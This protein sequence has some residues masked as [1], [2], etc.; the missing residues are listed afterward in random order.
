ML[1]GDRSGWLGARISVPAAELA[2]R[3]GGPG[4]AVARVRVL[5]K[6]G[7]AFEARDEG[8]ERLDLGGR[9]D[10]AGRLIGSAVAR[11]NE[12]HRDAGGMGG[13]GGELE[14]AIGG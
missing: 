14:Q 3:P 5:L 6:R 11:M 2:D 10:E 1:E 4:K 12:L 8:V 9:E 13:N 7:L